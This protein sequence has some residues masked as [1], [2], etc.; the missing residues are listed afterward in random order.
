MELECLWAE[1]EEYSPMEAKKYRLTD[2]FWYGEY[3]AQ[4][5][6]WSPRLDMYELVKANGGTLHHIDFAAFRRHKDIFERSIFVRGEEDFDIILPA[7]SE[8]GEDRLTIAHELGHYVLHA[9]RTGQ[10]KSFASRKGDA[11]VEKE[12]DCFALG[13]LMPSEE[14][15]KACE[16]YKT[17]FDLHL[18]FE[19]P[20]SAVRARLRSLNMDLTLY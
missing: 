6:A 15:R 11:P 7:H 18:F 17:V 5:L 9:D 12:A 14:F 13:F 8:F 1:R 3:E 10:R 20:E 19:V 2:V 4:A 16:K